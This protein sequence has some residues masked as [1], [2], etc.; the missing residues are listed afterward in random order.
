MTARLVGAAL[1]GIGTESWLSGNARVGEIR[2][3]L[4]LKVIWAFTATLAIAVCILQV[5]VPTTA[6]LFLFIFSG[7]LVLWTYYR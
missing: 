2:Q 5:V 4:N 1:M 6:R 7:F 3:I